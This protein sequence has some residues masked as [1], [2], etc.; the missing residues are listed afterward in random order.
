MRYSGQDMMGNTIVLEQKPERI[1]SLVPSQTE[2]LFDLG[3]D[4][5]VVGITKFC[6]HPESW[7]RTKS[8]VGGTKTVHFDRVKALQP[9]LIIAN[10][11]E[12][13]K[14]QIEALQSLAPVWL[15]DIKCVEDNLEMISHIGELTQTM[16]KA[17]VL[18][19]K[20]KT[21][22]AQLPI[23][24]VQG[25]KVAYLIWYNPIMVAGA[26]TFI[27]DLLSRIGLD[28]VFVADPR[29]PEQTWAQLQVAQP[30]YLLLSS[31]PFPFSQKHLQ[32]FQE[33]LPHAKIMLVDGELFSWYGSRMQY[34]V[35]YF[36]S[37]FS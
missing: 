35:P 26:D 28:N 17:S 5:E 32:I 12:N 30:E 25:R 20:I 36:K 16:D 13:V 27:H 15:S 4:Q 9:D 6:L 19:E 21:G 37:I 7:F 33:K 1:V 14:E 29:Y 2:L 34:A 23:M 18:I 11:E 24:P 22:F 10:K 31:E 3:L 8:R